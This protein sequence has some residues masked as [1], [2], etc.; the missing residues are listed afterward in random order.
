MAAVMP[1]APL[2]NINSRAAGFHMAMNGALIEKLSTKYAEEWLPARRALHGDK[3]NIAA[4][5]RW[6]AK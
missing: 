3:A 4:Y 5:M 6:L 2:T 1:V